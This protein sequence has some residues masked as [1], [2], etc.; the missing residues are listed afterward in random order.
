MSIVHNVYNGLDELID[1]FPEDLLNEV[2]DNLNTNLNW[3][4]APSAGRLEA[5]ISAEVVNKIEIFLRQQNFLDEDKNISYAKFYKDT[6]SVGRTCFY[7]PL[8]IDPPHV[9][10]GIQIYLNDAESPGIAWFN[11]DMYHK[12][13]N[14]LDSAVMM[15]CLNPD[16]FNVYVDKKFIDVA[17]GKYIKYGK[18]RGYMLTNSLTEPLPH[19]VPRSF[20]ADNRISLRVL[21]K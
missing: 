1:F 9:D 8:H 20:K 7:I 2:L 3:L 19:A 13:Y 14:V 6:V 16:I 15:P 12:F 21:I 11:T 18:N 10:K 17:K 5:E 4:P